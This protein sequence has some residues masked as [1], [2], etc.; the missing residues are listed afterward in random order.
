VG[1]TLITAEGPLADRRCESEFRLD[2]MH[3]PITLCTLHAQGKDCP[4]HGTRPRLPW[5]E[6]RP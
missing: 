5:E 3:D 6:P 2:K 4:R 1:V